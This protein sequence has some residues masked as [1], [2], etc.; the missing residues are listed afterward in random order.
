MLL[1][2]FRYL[3]CVLRAHL[4]PVQA[5]RPRWHVAFRSF[6]A[7]P[8]FLAPDQGEAHAC[9]LHAGQSRYGSWM[10]TYET[11]LVCAFDSSGANSHL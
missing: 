6:R 2:K 11:V 3:G 8:A 9:A 5:M 10:L 1:A 7:A 4:V